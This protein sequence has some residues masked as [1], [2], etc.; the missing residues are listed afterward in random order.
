MK[1][2]TWPNQE[3]NGEWVAE[4]MNSLPPEPLDPALELNKLL[5]SGRLVWKK[6]D[7]RAEKLLWIAFE[8]HLTGFDRTTARLVRFDFDMKPYKTAGIAFAEDRVYVGTSKGIV[9]YSRH[10]GFWYRLAV[11]GT[12]VDAPVTEIEMTK[13]GDLRVS[14]AEK[15]QPPRTFTFTPKSGKWQELPGR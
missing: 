4:F 7:P 12:F 9:V 13:D 1:I 8:D 3:A 11:A 15:G 6:E 14:I 10:D 5:E 2:W